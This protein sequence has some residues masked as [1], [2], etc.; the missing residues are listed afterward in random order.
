M[1]NILLREQAV[2]LFRGGLAR[3]T[4]E[5][6]V[7]RA[8][9]LEG[10]ALALRFL[11]RAERV[12]LAPGGRLV[13]LAVG[14]AA[15][16]MAAEAT[17]LLGGRVSAGLIVTK[18]SFG[19]A[20]PPFP[21]R[22]TG[23]PVPDAAGVAAAAEAEALLTGLGADDV[24]LV[25][26]SGGASALLPAPAPGIA[27]AEKQ[28]LVEAML[29]AEMDIH[30]INRVRKALSRFKGG[31]LAALAGPARVV[32]LYLSDVA[33]DALG[34]I[35]SG[36]T[37]PEPPD[38]AGAAALLRA[39]G[40]WDG[41]APAVRRLLEAGPAAQPP[42]TPARPPVNG[43]IGN[44]RHLLEAIAAEAQAA[45]FATDVRPEPLT[46]AVDAAVP[47]LL[48]AWR[49]ARRRRPT[50]PLAL[51][52]GGETVVAVK[53]HG[54]GGR[55]Q[56]LA[57]RMLP[58]LPPGTAF[59]AAGSDG[60]DGP[61]DAAGGAVDPES[62]RRLQAAGVPYHALLADNDSYVLLEAG[63]NLLRIP[64]TRNNLMDVMLFL[65]E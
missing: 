52:V 5:A 43:L 44:N 36:P 64:P 38:P 14:K 33:G 58:H 57:A 30:A 55:C 6:L 40:L 3:V 46:G 59:L 56:E 19:L 41:A 9:T 17:R 18:T 11:D 29:R 37:V 24:A 49:E 20:E 61:T 31:G 42:K 15:G 16:P 34:S 7:R 25:L 35:G 39:H 21:Q 63:G 48:T 45:G 26:V 4:P 2:A 28:A 54:R 23:H 53:G 1:V 60:N 65:E 22:E 50:G 10:D 47:L 8:L 13:L 12:P 27:L 51:I 32:G 62:W